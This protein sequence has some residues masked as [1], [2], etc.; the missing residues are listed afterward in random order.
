MSSV[1]IVEKKIKP[2]EGVEVKVDGK[3]VEVKG[4]L[5]TLRE[6]LTHMPVEISFDNEE[7]AIR[8]FWPRK[9]IAALVGT[10]ASLIQNMIAGV[11]KGFTYKLQV[12]H[13][14]FPM[15]VK[16][17]ESRRTVLIENF[18]GERT[19]RIAKIEGDA[20]VKASGDE[21]T[22]KGISLGSVSQTA[23]NIET[24]TKVKKKDQRV[25]LDGIYVYEKKK[26]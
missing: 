26:A 9:R 24:A 10:A 7:I 19:P 6:D 18:M 3:A 23:A 17:D 15:T 2:P 20:E 21:I 13:A 22:V 5:G 4:P 14:H 8:V 25:F 1:Q 12:V 11:T 16:V